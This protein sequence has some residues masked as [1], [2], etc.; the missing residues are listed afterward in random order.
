MNGLALSRDYYDDVG[1]AALERSF[2][3]M[4]SRMAVGLAGEGSECFGF[5]DAL[6]RD[7][8]WGPSFC[9]WLNEEDYRLRG[10]QVQAVY[11]SLSCRTPGIPPRQDGPRSGG[12]V[13]CLCAPEWYRRY[14]GFPEGPA[15]NMQWLSVPEAFLATASNGAVFSDPSGGFS[16]VRARLLDFYPEDVRIKKIAARA[17]IMAQSG[18]Y[19]YGRCLKRG[20]TVA[21]QLALGEFVKAG[22]SMVYLLNRRYAPYYKW[23]HRG[24]LALPLLPRTHAQ[25]AELCRPAPAA[26]KQEVIESVCADVIGELRAQ[27]LS[28]RTDD[29]LLEHCPDM[30]ARIQDPQLRNLHIMEG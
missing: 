1:R 3:Q 6:S 21:A 2:P 25:F 26:G 9:I 23:T 28:E 24:L 22:M 13:G 11:E 20:E 7:H 18:Q 29:F 19:N 4:I 12:R 15:A 17:A 16:A 30:M 10:S 14:T 5:D 27:G 8:D